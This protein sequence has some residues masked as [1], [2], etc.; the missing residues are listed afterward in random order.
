MPNVANNPIIRIAC[1]MQDEKGA[2]YQSYIAL[3]VVSSSN[4]YVR[5]YSTQQFCAVVES[6]C[7]CTGDYRQRWNQAGLHFSQ[8]C[9]YL[10]KPQNINEIL[11]L[12]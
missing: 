2:F 7:D 4:S 10:P 5:T 8:N 9:M 3:P 11:Y 12:Y 6:G 1:V